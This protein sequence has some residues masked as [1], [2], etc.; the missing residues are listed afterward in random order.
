M[1]RVLFD[2]RV[3]AHEH[4]TGV[5]H[6]T[7][8]I[9]EALAE[10]MEIDRA[11][12]SVSNRYL[13]QLWNHF[14][15][16]WKKGDLLFS[17]ANMAPLFVPKRKKF[18]VTL[19]DMAFLTFPESFSKPFRCY[20][21]KIV[22]RIVRRADRII[23]MS[24]ASK[25]EIVRYFPD[26][27]EKI[28]VIYQGVDPRFKP[29]KRERK[30][31]ILYVGSFNERK[32]FKAVIEAFE[33]VET[34]AYKLVLAGNFSPNFSLGSEVLET[35]ERARHDPRIEFVTAPSLPELLTLYNES[36]L[37]LFPSLYEG[38]GLPP[39][40]AMAC[41]T[42]VVVSDRSSM[43]EV[44]GE[45]ALYCDPLDVESIAEKIA[46]LL[47]SESLRKEMAAKGLARVKKFSWERSAEE[48]MAV[49]REV[50]EEGEK[51]KEIEEGKR[52]C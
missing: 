15:L 2:A 14:V 16:P 49:F 19:H 31:Q 27:E 3:L 32:N 26:A 17:P 8:H 24:Y 22:P 1:K 11:L 5:E 9:Y 30:R 20:Y 23:T 50:L 6:Y 46:S 45:A 21:R 42:P 48:H 51:S 43:P 47:E 40:E 13:L 33:R 41:G 7:R 18:V 12:P 44:C 38:F 39:L 29:L 10:R 4:Y 34:T 37:F 28:R 35:I 36:A 25:E 52:A